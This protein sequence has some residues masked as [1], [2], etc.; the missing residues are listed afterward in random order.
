MLICHSVIELLIIKGHLAVPGTSGATLCL[1]HH[2][3]EQLPCLSLHPV[4]PSTNCTT[5]G[6]NFN[7]FVPSFPHL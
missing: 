4:L 5:L 2:G 6:K 3:G 1:Y 7:F